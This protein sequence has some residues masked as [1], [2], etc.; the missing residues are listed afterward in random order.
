MIDGLGSVESQGP[1]R[2][3]SFVQFLKRE[4]LWIVGF[5]ILYAFS[6]GWSAASAS[7]IGAGCGSSTRPSSD[8]FSASGVA[9]FFLLVLVFLIVGTTV[10]ATLAPA[11]RLSSSVDS[12]E[13]LMRPL[14]ARA[15][16]SPSFVRGVY[17]PPANLYPHF[18][19]CQT[20]TLH[21]LTVL[22]IHL[23]HSCFP[24]SP[25]TISTYCRR[26]TVPYRALKPP[27]SPIFFPISP[28]QLPIFSSYSQ[29]P[30]VPPSSPRFSVRL[31]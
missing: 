9:T 4:S 7:A 12:V 28:S 23:G 1:Q 30:S 29:P 13:G 27:A 11:R 25:V 3:K 15:A 6:T 10:T 26:V 17:A 20:P 2:R 19:Q 5:L 18:L 14:V 22:N 31:A 16:I 21:L 8:F 24:L